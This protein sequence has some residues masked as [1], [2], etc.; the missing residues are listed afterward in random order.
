VAHQ[1][2]QGLGR[3]L[4]QHLEK[5]VGGVGVHRLGLVDDGDAPAALDGRHAQLLVHPA[6]MRHD[7]LVGRLARVGMHHPALQGEQVRM[8]TGGDAAEHRMPGIERQ[9]IGRRSGRSA[10]QRVLPG[11]RLGGLGQHEAGK[12]VSQRRLADPARAGDQPAMRDAARVPGLQQGSLG[13]ALP[14][15]MRVGAGRRR[16][17]G[18]VTHGG[19]NL[20]SVDRFGMLSYR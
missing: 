18:K 6:H 10:E 2:D 15:Q 7:D 5:R 13:R 14:D 3:R 1:Q 9:R 19:R 16:F 8:A 4:F 17:G 12:A 11:I 20:A